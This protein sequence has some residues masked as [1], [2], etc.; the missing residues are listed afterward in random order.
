MAKAKKFD[1][2][3]PMLHLVPYSFIRGTAIGFM[4]GIG[5]YGKWNWTL[6]LNWSRIYD[7]A[8]RH[9]DAFF[10]EH[11]DIDKDS[12]LPHLYLA[13]CNLAMLTE[14]YEKHLGKDDRH[15][16][17]N[18]TKKHRSTDKKTRSNRRKKSR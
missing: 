1:N 13:C 14:H 15:E 10:L 3:K 7:A 8:R 12:G 18:I 2:G 11:E 6:G 4:H 16:Y 9:L 5:K 17:A